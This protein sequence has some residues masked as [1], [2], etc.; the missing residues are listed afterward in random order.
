MSDMY[1]GLLEGI[2]LPLGDI[3]LGSTYINKLREWRKI[4]SLSAEE[5]RNM[6]RSALDKLLTFASAN[7]PFYKNLNI[8]ANSDPYARI[9]NFPIMTKKVIK[10]N[11]DSMVLED[12]S[13]LIKMASSG[14]S[15]IQGVV[16]VDKNA[17]S[18]HQA[19]QTLWW[20]WAGYKFGHKLLQTG[21][22]PNRG[23]VKTIKD[24]LL[25][26]HYVSAYNLDPKEI[27]SI[28][29][30]I[31]KNPVDH[32]V[33]YASSLFV[34]AKVAEENN[35]ND[36]SFKS[37]VSWGDKMFPHFRS[38][39]EKQFHTEVYDTYGCAE[40]F[41]IAAE[42]KN[43]NYH[44]MTPLLH[45]EIVDDEGNEVPSGTLGN[46]IVTRL[47]TYAMPLIR[48]RLG[49]LAIKDDPNATC[50]CGMH[51]PLLKKIVG[52]DTDI[53]KTNSGKYMVVHAFTGIFEHVPEIKQFRVIQK[54]LDG[55]EIEYIKDQN[56][57][58]HIL[59]QIK[60]KIDGYLH[61]DFPIYFKEVDFIPPTASGKPQIIQSFL[62]QSVSNSAN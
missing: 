28:L 2:I 58:D 20:E 31:Q 13:K 42:C 57:G 54:N 14:S 1:N 44:I 43:H 51:F 60:A 29:K 18:T 55:I 49:D 52:R 32:F 40:G 34:F 30:D 56:F 12:K 26:T 33:G 7:S 25:R 39:I 19:I 48:Y 37:V 45:L 46:V 15:G 24:V 21:I 36:I 9:K 38:M 47:D 61:E 50:G 3:A 8:P 62:K 23:V 10:E 6:Q 59:N 11:M 16:Y 35:I 53:V 5:L 17:Q 41:M 22:T 4:Q 27:L